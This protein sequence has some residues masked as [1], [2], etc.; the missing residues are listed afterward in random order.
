MP[1]LW[2][3]QDPST[4]FSSRTGHTTCSTHE[5]IM[6]LIFPGPFPKAEHTTLFYLTVHGIVDSATSGGVWGL[7]C[8]HT[9]L[10]CYEGRL[11]AAGQVNLHN[12]TS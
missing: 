9:Q 8:S 12:S 4:Y 5:P 11:S 6:T 3:I 2:L 1:K 10:Q 7:A